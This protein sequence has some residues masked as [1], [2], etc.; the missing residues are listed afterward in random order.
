MN[1][2]LLAVGLCLAYLEEQAGVPHWRIEFLRGGAELVRACREE[3]GI[4]VRRLRGG[5]IFD[6]AFVDP[7]RE[8]KKTTR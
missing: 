4:T 8:E 7:Q 3:P 5:R 6:P 2:Y 1:A